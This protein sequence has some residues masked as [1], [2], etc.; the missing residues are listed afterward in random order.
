MDA[1]FDTFNA[2]EKAVINTIY[3]DSDKYGELLALL[4]D[5]REEKA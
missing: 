3:W 4:L 5:Y 1:L 2:K